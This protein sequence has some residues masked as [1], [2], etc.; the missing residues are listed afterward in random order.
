MLGKFGPGAPLPRLK[1]YS[2]S[3]GDVGPG[4][5]GA[6]IS[7]RSRAVT[8]GKGPLMRLRTSFAL[9]LGSAMLLTGCASE[10]PEPKFA[11]PS[12]SPSVVKKEETAE[13]FIRRWA[14]V[15][16]EMQNTGE[17]E[18]YRAITRGCPSCNSLADKMEEIYRDGG[19]VKSGE[20]EVRRVREESPGQY[21]V[22]LHVSPTTHRLTE[23][24]PDGGFPGGKDLVQLNLERTPSGWNLSYYTRRAA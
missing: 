18:E 13:E 11:E 14:K 20:I 6:R 2:S 4:I 24:G 5:E 23:S 9:L 7:L 8:P 19:W 15:E 17:T 22:R 16:Q 1:A 21:L 12:A 10:E 3:T